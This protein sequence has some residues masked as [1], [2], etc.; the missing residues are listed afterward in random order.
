MDPIN[1]QVPQAPSRRYIPSPTHVRTS[2]ATRVCDHLQHSRAQDCSG[3]HNSTCESR[4]TRESAFTAEFTCTT[5]TPHGCES[6]VVL[7]GGGV[8]GPA[9]VPRFWPSFVAPVLFLDPLL[10][11][12]EG[13]QKQDGR[14]KRGPKTRYNRRTAPE[15]SGGAPQT[16]TALKAEGSAD[17]GLESHER[18]LKA[19][20]GSGRLRAPEITGGAP[21]TSARVQK[22]EGS[23]RGVGRGAGARDSSSFAGYSYKD[24]IHGSR[25]RFFEHMGV[26]GFSNLDALSPCHPPTPLVRAIK[27]GVAIQQLCSISFANTP[28]AT[29]TSGVTRLGGSSIL[30]VH[31][32]RLLVWRARQCVCVCGGGLRESPEGCWNLRWCRWLRM[33]IKQRAR[34]VS[35]GQSQDASSNLRSSSKLSRARGL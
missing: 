29:C 14:Y 3:T 7:E 18:I 13:L 23:A 32:G 17:I 19:E 24:S 31:A 12:Q 20:E 11:F 15:I 22:S 34:E 27:Y 25:P 6:G 35:E 1:L 21:Q 8:S 2:K 16:S 26:T 9:I 28:F 4:N 33:R 10:I 30:R 5:S